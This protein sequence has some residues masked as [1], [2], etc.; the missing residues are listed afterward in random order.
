[1]VRI[2]CT[3]EIADLH[4]LL[5]TEESLSNSNLRFLRCYDTVLLRKF[6]WIQNS[7]VSNLWE[8]EV[9][10]DLNV[11][12]FRGF[13]FEEYLN[14]LPFF[15]GVL[16]VSL[17]HLLFVSSANSF[18]SKNKLYIFIPETVTNF[19]TCISW[20]RIRKIGLASE[21]G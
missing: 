13:I 3:R 2:I 7:E 8:I 1:M 21:A 10:C 6:Q 19:V 9:Q 4:A 11:H 14:F 16:R 17:V 15:V 5:V 12:I 18:L 20:S